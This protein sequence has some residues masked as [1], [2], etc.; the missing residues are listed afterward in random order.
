[1][2]AG[3]AFEGD[4]FVGNRVGYMVGADP[5]ATCARPGF[6]PNR[7]REDRF[8]RNPR[9]DPRATAFGCCLLYAHP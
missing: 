7:S 6:T 2:S 8:V 9:Q 5:A 1:M 3:N 4:E